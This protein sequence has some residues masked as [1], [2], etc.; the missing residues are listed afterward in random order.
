MHNIRKNWEINVNIVQHWTISGFIILCNHI[1]SH[2]FIPSKLYCLKP[3]VWH[4]HL[5]TCTSPRTSLRLLE[6]ATFYKLFYR[7]VA[8]KINEILVPQSN[9]KTRN[10]AEL[11][12]LCLKLFMWPPNV[13]CNIIIWEWKR[14]SGGGGG[15][16]SPSYLEIF[17]FFIIWLLL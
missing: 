5:R 7:I 15:Y 10:W 11:L 12:V 8:R 4:R 9:P 1:T 16:N 17:H 14:N 6:I 13:T 2:S 3:F